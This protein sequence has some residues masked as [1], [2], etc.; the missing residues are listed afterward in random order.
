MFSVRA[1]VDKKLTV[2]FEDEKCTTLNN[3][4]D[5]MG[6]GKNNGKLVYP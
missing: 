4:G 6:T 3:N 1:V 5:M 2:I